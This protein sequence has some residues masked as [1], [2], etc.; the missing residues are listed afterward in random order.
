M[1]GPLARRVLL[2]ATGRVVVIMAALVP[3]AGVHASGARSQTSA[4]PRTAPRST[5]PDKSGVQR[6]LKEKRYPDA[7]NAARQLLA[8]AETLNGKDSRAAAE[9][10]NLLMEALLFQ[11]KSGEEPQALATR[12]VAL[13]ESLGDDELQLACSIRNLAVLRGRQGHYMEARGL[14]ERAFAIQDRI[15]P[16]DNALLVNTMALLAIMRG[17]VG[18]YTGARAL[19]ERVLASHEKTLGPDHIETASALNN[20]GVM[21][22]EMGDYASAGALLERSMDIHERAL[23][24]DDPE[25]AM[26]MGNVALLLGNTR[27]LAEAQR[28]HLRALA[29]MEKAHGPD[30]VLVGQALNN[31]GSVQKQLGDFTESTRSYRRALAI[32]E[33]ALGPQHPAVG[34]ALQNV[35]TSF[36]NTGDLPEA[37]RALERAIAIWEH[38]IGPGHPALGPAMYSLAAVLTNMRNWSAAVPMALRAEDVRRAHVRLTIR[39]LSE[40]EALVYAS[41]SPSALH[42][43][44]ALAEQQPG[45]SRR[46][47]W[48]AVIRSRTL[49]LDELAMRHRRI[50]TSGDAEVAH[51]VRQ[52]TTARD[53]LARLSVRG[54]EGA[55]EAA[56]GQN[57]MARVRHEREQAERLL[58]ASSSA[59]PAGN[60][61]EQAG[62]DQVLAALPADGVLVAFARYRRADLR[63]EAPDDQAAPTVPSYV[64]FIGG[65]GHGEPAMV[66]IGKAEEI[67]AL[68]ADWRDAIVEQAAST[69]VGQ[70]R[71]ETSYRQ[72]ASALRQRIWDPLRPH[73][74][75]ATRVTVVLDGALHLVNMAALPD[76]DDG[77]LVETG[78]QISYVT[79][80]RDLALRPP[81]PSGSGIL[82]MGGPA[83]SAPVAVGAAQPPTS[84]FRGA[85]SQCADFR[86]L[87]FDSLPAA[88]REAEDVAA[89]WGTGPQPGDSSSSNRT[90]RTRKLVLTGSSATEAALKREAPGR[91]V[92]HLATHAFFLGT[93]CPS[94]LD[95]T[96]RASAARGAV[97]ENPLMLAGLVM[98]GANE[99]AAALP[100]QDDGILTAEEIAAMDLTGVEWAVLSGCDT[101]IGRLRAGEGAFGLRRAFQIAGARTV[102]MSLWPV[103][104]AT[105][106][107]WMTTLYTRRFRDGRSTTEAVRE[108]SLSALGKRRTSGASTHPFY[109]AGFVAVGDPR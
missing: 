40:R 90:G 108:A 87:R 50:A 85:P 91:R 65:P 4:S 35:G 15:G 97:G 52:L 31:L 2:P 5:P 24:P 106:H 62:V 63:I 102:I 89:L 16:P 98:A 96:R 3:L 51:R 17:S 100:D 104:D 29:I 88:G 69:G 23:G 86:S 76:G 48:D 14:A 7:E 34:T 13:H 77:Y 45:V 74:A 81:A 82:A 61:R 101:G 32:Y 80:E 107:E 79:A 49:V 95:T 84:A 58:A 38:S 64:A 78:P 53:R 99:R 109:W 44:I 55:T 47:V 66:P 83:Y 20:F 33:S 27:K 39:S 12:A 68:V 30:H 67:D 56:D 42:L 21:L 9:A 36:A 93:T 43:A 75:T 57:E 46:L 1:T 19:H 25:V 54:V 72:R 41:R 28:L 8:N 71:L 26:V 6:L 37:Q 70:K 103:D 94:A 10:L 59:D 92:L 18:D 22:W 60:A 11:R 73:I 105:T